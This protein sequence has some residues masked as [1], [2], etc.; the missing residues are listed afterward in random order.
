MSDLLW[1]ILVLRLLTGE[2][3]TI[4]TICRKANVRGSLAVVVKWCSAAGPGS[5]FGRHT[6][7][8]VCRVWI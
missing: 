4:I 1:R 6:A 5:P 7:G 8:Y 2:G 3:T